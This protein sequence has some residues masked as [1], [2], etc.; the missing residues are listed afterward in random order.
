[1]FKCIGQC[2]VC[3]NNC[4]RFF[5]DRAVREKKAKLFFLPEDFTPCTSGEGYGIAF[6]IGTTTVVG[7]LW[8]MAGGKF[9]TAASKTNPQIKYGAD[10]ISRIAF[11]GEK[12]NLQLLHKLIIGCLNDILDIICKEQGIKRERIVRA[13][14][15]G[16]TT[17]SHILLGVNPKTLALAPFKPGYTGTARSSAEQLGIHINPDAEL[18]VMPNIAGHIGGDITAGIV[19]T[20]LEKSDKNCLYIDIGTNGEIVLCAGGKLFAAST[21]AGP[22][23]EGASIYQGMR[24]AQGV[25]E[26]VKIAHGDILF[27][28][29]SGRPPVGICGSGLI[30]AVAQMLEHGLIN[31]T[32]KLLSA[33]EYEREH[34]ES[35]LCDYIA[36]DEDCRKIIIAKR[37]DAQ[38]IVIT[39]KDIREVQLAKAAIA[40]GIKCL[41]N[42]AKLKVADLDCI[43]LAGAFGSC[44]DTASAIAIGLLPEVD[45]NKVASVGNAAG[46]GVLMA[47]GDEKQIEIM[48]RIPEITQHIELSA[49]AD[50]QK[51]FLEAM[52]F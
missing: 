36:E 29:I 14:A 48:Q 39:Q 44:I 34:G 4:H 23:F 32:G 1:M 28:T 41:L 11:A 18:T 31:S 43:Y 51:L 16:N 15:C 10:V 25:I 5:E 42:N 6:D 45:T 33:E 52:A 30:D 12:E 13:V 20:R 49:E 37:E 19:A 3:K 40:A 22:A 8:D 47:L 24:A 46:A 17:M 38:D 2:S 35:S 7:L 27:K 50:F 26:K 21:A 9:V